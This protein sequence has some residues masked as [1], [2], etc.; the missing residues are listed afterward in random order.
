MLVAEDRSNGTPELNRSIDEQDIQ[1]IDNCSVKSKKLLA[2]RAE[3][4][5]K[6]NVDVSVHVSG[7][8]PA[9]LSGNGLQKTAEKHSDNKGSKHWEW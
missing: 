5:S 6:G 8:I 3:I 4:N 2:K 1:Q 9:N 7:E